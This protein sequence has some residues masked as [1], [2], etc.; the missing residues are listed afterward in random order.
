MASIVDLPSIKMELVL[1]YPFVY[2]FVYDIVLVDKT[3]KEINL[4]L[5]LYTTFKSE[6]KFYMK[7]LS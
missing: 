3:R 7:Y 5:K 6:D 2:S 4:K 1:R